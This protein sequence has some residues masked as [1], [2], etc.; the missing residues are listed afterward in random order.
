MSES[1]NDP[2]KVSSDLNVRFFSFEKDEACQ[3]ILITV[4]FQKK[5]PPNISPPIR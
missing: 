1:W 4:K 3:S 2:R 5:A